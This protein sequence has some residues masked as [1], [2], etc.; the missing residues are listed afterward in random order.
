MSCVGHRFAYLRALA[1]TGMVERLKDLVCLTSVSIALDCAVRVLKHMRRAPAVA[2]SA[3]RKA[4]LMPG[5][6]RAVVAKVEG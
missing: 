4:P 1:S 3:H 2:V 6:G 5:A